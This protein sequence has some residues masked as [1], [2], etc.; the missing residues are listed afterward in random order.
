MGFTPTKSKCTYAD[1]TRLALCR[2]FVG[3]TR[4]RTSLKRNLHICLTALNHNFHQLPCYFFKIKIPFPNEATNTTSEDC[5]VLTYAL[6]EGAWHSLCLQSLIILNMGVNH[7]HRRDQSARYHETE[8]CQILNLKC[9]F[10][11]IRA[12]PVQIQRP[13]VDES[14][15]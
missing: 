4:G 9:L 6:N 3:S 14:N 15:E 1:I 13:R 5:S 12:N 7:G 2:W 8:L 10:C 11:R